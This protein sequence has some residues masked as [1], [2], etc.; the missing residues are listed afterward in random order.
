MSDGSNGSDPSQNNEGASGSTPGVPEIEL[1]E[2]TATP[3]TS[4]TPSATS[5]PAL[6]ASRIVIRRIGVDSVI[7]ES[8]I[9]NGEWQVP[10]FV[11]G[12]LEGTSN[13]G[14]NGNLVLSGHLESIS[15]GN[16]FA[17]LNEIRQGDE[18][19]LFTTRDKEFKYQVVEIKTV[20]N[21]DIS[22]VQA[23]P[24]PMI[25]LITCAGNFNLLT[26]DYSHRLIVIAK[27]SQ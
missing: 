24:E 20:A 10:K 3:I 4:P 25:T 23:T 14:E 21:N 8:K 22:V 1:L 2:A 16:V 17:R 18:I 26:R 5:A 6:P 11:V 15:S 27:P 12:H 19:T 13:P 7:R 9:A